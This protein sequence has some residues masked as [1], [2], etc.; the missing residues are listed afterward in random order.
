MNVDR[1]API[2]I[3]DSGVGGLTVARQVMRELP[4]E[5]IVYFGDTARAPYGVHST[6]RITAQTM[7]IMR[8]L[9]EKRLKMAIIACNTICVSSYYEIQGAFSLPV[10]EILSPAAT[11]CVILQPPAALVGVI[12]TDATCKSEGYRVEIQ[13]RNPN[14][15]VLHKPCPQLVVLAEQ[16]LSASAAAARQCEIYLADFK[17]CGIDTLILGC[18]HFPMFREHIAAYLGAG[19]RLIDPATATAAKLRAALNEA[20]LCADHK[21]PAHEFYISGDVPTFEHIGKELLGVDVL[22]ERVDI[23]RY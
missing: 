13:K 22:A 5:R 19:V 3:F 23:E 8:F 2:G 16:G 7:Q 9:S 10:L 4:G 1:N 6:D 12:A 21:D 15:T 18:T 20:G 11:E 17:A 14:I